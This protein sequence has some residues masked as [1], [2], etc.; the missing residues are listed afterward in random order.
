[1]HATLDLGPVVDG[2]TVQTE[3][4]CVDWRLSPVLEAFQHTVERL[5]L[6]A[7]YLLATEWPQQPCTKILD[8][9]MDA[10]GEVF[11]ERL[12]SGS[13]LSNQRVFVVILGVRRQKSAH[14]V[15]IHG[16]LGLTADAM[17]M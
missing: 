7:G 8:H 16:R 15:K 4:H 13:H 12:A 10:V 1:V 9:R 2:Q 3:H 6:V 14:T 17:C 11:G 5:G